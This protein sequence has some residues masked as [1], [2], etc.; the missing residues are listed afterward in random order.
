[1]GTRDGDDDRMGR[2]ELL[3][4]LGDEGGIGHR[5]TVELAQLTLDERILVR[6]PP[7]V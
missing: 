2:H 6:A 1:M 5:R 3:L 7:L 4:Q